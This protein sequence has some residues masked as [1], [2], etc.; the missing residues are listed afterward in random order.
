MQKGRY[1]FAVSVPAT[2]SADI[3]SLKGDAPRPAHIDVT[4]DDTNSFLASTLGRSAMI[5]ILSLIHI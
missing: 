3:A 5:Q 1:Y 4:Y 2:Y